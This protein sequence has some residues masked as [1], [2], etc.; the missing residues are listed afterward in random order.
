[1]RRYQQGQPRCGAIALTGTTSVRR[2]PCGAI[3]G[4]PRCGARARSCGAIQGRRVGGVLMSTARA[5]KLSSTMATHRNPCWAELLQLFPHHQPGL[6]IHRGGQGRTL[7]GRSW[8]SAGRAADRANLPVAVLWR[9]HRLNPILIGTNLWLWLGLA[10]FYVPAPALTTWLI[11]TK[12]FG[13]FALALVVGIAATFWFLR[14]TSP[15]RRRPRW[16]RRTS[17][18]LLGLTV[19]IVLWA[20]MLPPEHAGLGGGLPFIVLNLARGVISR[21]AP[22]SPTT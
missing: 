11:E 8:F 18:V 9:R 4:Q 14:A 20:W 17:L 21:K 7:A 12:A 5:R 13:L 10:A 16:T 22:V 3:Q 19:V 6:S 1:M 15:A 2:Y